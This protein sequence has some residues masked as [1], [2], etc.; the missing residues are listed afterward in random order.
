MVITERGHLL[1]DSSEA[2]HGKGRRKIWR[3]L[4]IGV[5]EETLEIHIDENLKQLEQFQNELVKES[6]T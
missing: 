5:D 1:N 2:K 3:K 6:Y 4:H